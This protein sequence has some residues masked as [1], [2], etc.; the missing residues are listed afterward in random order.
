MPFKKGCSVQIRAE[1]VRAAAGC[2]LLHSFHTP[3]GFVGVVKTLRCDLDGASVG[4]ILRLHGDAVAAHVRRDSAKV[5]TNLHRTQN[6]HH[7]ISLQPQ[8]EPKL[9]EK[10]IANAK[11]A[12]SV[13]ASLNPR[14]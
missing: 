14:P 2:F 7:V 5:P 6:A 12:A 8:E 13:S 1:A 3:I 4:V 10:E 11:A 9:Q